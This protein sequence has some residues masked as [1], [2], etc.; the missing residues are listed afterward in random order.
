MKIKTHIALIVAALLAAIVSAQPDP[1]A[2]GAISGTLRWVCATNEP[3]ELE[4]LYE[5][6]PDWT[7]REAVVTR[8]YAARVMDQTR[9][10]HEPVR[11]VVSNLWCDFHVTGQLYSF[12]LTNQVE[13]SRTN[14][15]WQLQKIVK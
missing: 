7:N 14:Y 15:S 13:V 10:R 4:K 5:T 11:V 6:S 9:I 2:P 3:P 12:Q 8:Q 1:V